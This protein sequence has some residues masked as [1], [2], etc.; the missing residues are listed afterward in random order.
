MLFELFG[1]KIEIRYEIHERMIAMKDTLFQE[2]DKLKSELVTLSTDIHQNPELAFEEHKSAAFVAELMKGHGF[3]VEFPVGGLATAFKA[4]YNGSGDGPTIAFMAEYDALPEMGHACG[5]NLIAMASAG[6]AIGVSKIMNKLPGKVVLLGTPAE[7]LGGGKIH[8]IT[9]GAFEGIDFALM[10]HP[11]RSNKV[12]GKSLAITDVT[13][14]FFGRPAHSSR[15]EDGINA[16][17]AIL[18][19]FYLIDSLRTAM[20]VKTNINGIINEGGK[21][22]NIIPEYAKATF[23]VRG[24]TVKDLQTVLEMVKSAIRA[25][26]SFTGATARVDIDVL[27]A[28]SYENMAMSEVYKKHMEEFGDKV[29]YQDPNI[30]AGSSDTANVQ[31][32]MPAI[33]PGFKVCDSHVVGHTLEYRDACL[34]DRAHNATIKAAKALAA[35]AY[36]LFTDEN[37]RT[38]TIKEFKETVPAYTDEDTKIIH[39]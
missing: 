21:A 34:T 38:A 27:Y 6:A 31:I 22:A 13:V 39:Y 32:K 8:M 10:A 2:I 12:G 4:T 25:A 3:E 11:G 15:P 26:E 9:N 24:A 28:E 14:E 5:H 30:K 37:L 29:E 19:T 16:L 35:T 20:P 23:A 33:Q 1:Y 17:A 18:H 7:E 36:E